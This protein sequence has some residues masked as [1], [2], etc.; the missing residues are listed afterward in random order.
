MIVSPP[1]RIRFIAMLPHNGEIHAVHPEVSAR[2]K[3]EGC[4]GNACA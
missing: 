1:I 4:E 3:C 2:Q